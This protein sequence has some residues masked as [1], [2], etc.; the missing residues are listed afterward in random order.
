[1][2][3]Y[4]VY[5]TG[6]I[7]SG[8]AEVLTQTLQSANV[9]N[10]DILINL[11]SPGGSVAE[12]LKLGR[13]IEKLKASTNVGQEGIQPGQCLSACVWVFLGGAYRYLS[14][15]S[16]IGVHQ[17][18][19][20]TKSDVQAGVAVAASQVIAAEIVEFIRENRA[21]TDFFKF[22]AAAS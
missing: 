18:A 7:V 15:E 11:N 3:T 2:I 6:E 9:V 17:F 19:F 13:L 4:H 20:G 16:K 8:D 1:G 21:N 22:V 14:L 5:A 10:A 12:A